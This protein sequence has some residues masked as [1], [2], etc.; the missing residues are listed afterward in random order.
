LPAIR[1]AGLH[2][3]SLFRRCAI[4]S[5]DSAEEKSKF[6][7]KILFSPTQA[8]TF[9]SRLKTTAIFV[10]F[11]HL[12][13]IM[14]GP[15]LPAACVLLFR[16]YAFTHPLIYESAYWP[17][18]VHAGGGIVILVIRI[19]IPPLL[20]RIGVW[21]CLTYRRLRFGY[22]FRKI[23]LTQG[24][25]AIVDPVDYAHLAKYKWR[26][27]RTK[28]KNVTYAERSIR[29]PNGKY[30][31]ILMHRE[32]LSLSK[33]QVLNLPAVSLSNPSATRMIEPSKAP[34]LNPCESL[35]PNHYSRATSHERLVTNF[36]IDH[37]C[38]P[39]V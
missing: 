34:F 6:S 15:L 28:G 12:R 24:K 36:I 27:C 25:F 19:K 26:L 14:A 8:L 9:L 29:L 13:L 10:K 16:I 4:K 39:V 38:C 18:Y 11:A 17:T 20:E 3:G 7:K 30:S 1:V 33:G 23:P 22:P 2:G 35:N 31:R 21:F 37:H 32:V 5:A